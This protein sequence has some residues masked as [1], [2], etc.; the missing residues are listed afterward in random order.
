MRLGLLSDDANLYLVARFST[1]SKPLNL[2]PENQQQGFR[3]GD[4]LQVRLA[5]GERKVNL[6]VWYDSANGKPALTAD[7]RDLAHPRLLRHGAKAACRFGPG[8][9]TLAMAI[10]WQNSSRALPRMPEN[11]CE[12]LS[13]RGGRASIR[14]SRCPAPQTRTPQPARLHL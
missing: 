3:G 2:Q 11:E 9:Y 1:P 14:V 10:P 12:R 6:C 8:Q 7:G 13:S 5:R 4:C